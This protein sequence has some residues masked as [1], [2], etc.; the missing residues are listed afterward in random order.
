[1]KRLALVMLAVVLSGAANSADLG[2]RKVVAPVCV[3]TLDLEFGCLDLQRQVP[4]LW[5]DFDSRPRSAVVLKPNVRP[6]PVFE[7]TD[8]I[9]Y[10]TTFGTEWVYSC[11]PGQGTKPVIL[12]D[13]AGEILFENDRR[14]SPF[15]AV[16]LR[17]T[18][19]S[20]RPISLPKH[21]P[22]PASPLKVIEE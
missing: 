6:V 22:T 2:K 19:A 11:P 17:S 1:V 21:I 9:I 15:A 5:I 10:T 14:Q 3:T 16:S 13:Q 12:R 20:N 18:F 8:L 4:S 7:N